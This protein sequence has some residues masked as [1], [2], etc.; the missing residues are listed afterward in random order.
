MDETPESDLVF[1]VP[2]S[3]GDSELIGVAADNPLGNFNLW[4]SSYFQIISYMCFS[5]SAVR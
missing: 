1:I 4:H 3:I 2:S 5:E